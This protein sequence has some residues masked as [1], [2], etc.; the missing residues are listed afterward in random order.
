LKVLKITKVYHFVEDHEKR[1][2]LY[3][4]LRSVTKDH[5]TYLLTDLYAI[6]S[7][8]FFMWDL[9]AEINTKRLTNEGKIYF[10]CHIEIHRKR[11]FTRENLAVKFKGKET[12]AIKFQE[13]L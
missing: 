10:V 13:N 8:G 3:W 11:K 9:G 4:V 12:S 5:K 1:V 7:E 2:D 6:E